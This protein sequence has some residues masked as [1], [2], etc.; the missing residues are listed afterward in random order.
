MNTHYLI[1]QGATLQDVQFQVN[2]QIES[3]AWQLHEGLVY[4]PNALNPLW[5][6]CLKKWDK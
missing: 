1:V 5:I 4:V 6:Q 3:G 2:Q